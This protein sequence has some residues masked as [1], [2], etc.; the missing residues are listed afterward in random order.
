MDHGSAPPYGGHDGRHGGRDRRRQSPSPQ[1]RRG[2]REVVVHRTESN[3]A[4][5]QFPMLTRTNYQE[6]AML[7]QVNLEAAGWWYA[8]EP[9]E[10]EEVV[11]R[12]DRLAL[13]AI[14]RSVPADMLLGLRQKRTVAKAWEAIR[15]I[16][17]GVERVQKANAQHLRWEFG[18]LVWKE[19]ETA[20][21]FANRITGLAVDLRLL[22]DNISDTEVVRKILQLTP[23]HLIQVAISI[24]TLLDIRTISVE[25]VTGR[26]RAVEQRRKKAP[27]L[28]GQ[29]WLLLCEEEWWARL[30]IHEAEGKGGGS[31]F[32]GSGSSGGGSGKKRGGRGRGHGRGKGEGAG[33]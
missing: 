14:L 22:G 33:A 18:A 4:G 17:I 5:T 29:G 20:E 12:H 31:N 19:A 27:V 9:F 13:A 21:D 7:M 25:E 32:G 6:W 24:E 11:Y 23:E 1:P 15:R 16:R 28:D 8:V 30:K 3:A 10:E 26:L 2:R